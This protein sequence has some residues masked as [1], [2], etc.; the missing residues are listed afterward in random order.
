[1]PLGFDINGESIPQPHHGWMLFVDQSKVTGPHKVDFLYIYKLMPHG[2]PVSVSVMAE[3]E[4]EKRITEI[5]L[6]GFNGQDGQTVFNELSDYLR[7]G[8]YKI[9]TGNKF[10]L[11]LGDG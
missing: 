3:Y 11:K 4:A 6:D 8:K 9:E 2:E 1:M 5:Y 10:M 7:L